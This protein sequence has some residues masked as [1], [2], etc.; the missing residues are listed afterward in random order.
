MTT[1]IGLHNTL[2]GLLSPYEGYLL[3]HFPC[4]AR[5]ISIRNTTL[6]VLSLFGRYQ[7]KSD[8]KISHHLPQLIVLA[9]A[10]HRQKL[11]ITMEM[12]WQVSLHRIQHWRT[13][14]TFPRVHPV[15]VSNAAIKFPRSVS[16][17]DARTPWYCAPLAGP[18]TG[19]NSQNTNAAR[20]QSAYVMKEAEP[21]WL[22][23]PLIVLLYA[24]PD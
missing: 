12:Y 16:A 6:S 15:T 11:Y 17:V 2:V 21:T 10:F 7:R 18:W 20:G 4:Y 3:Q 14:Q 22:S 23:F 8:R 1:S 19:C 24:A 9:A 13:S 5:V